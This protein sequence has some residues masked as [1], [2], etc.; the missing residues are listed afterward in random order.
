MSV[1]VRF[2]EATKYRPETIGEHPPLDW[3]QQ[4]LPYKAYHAEPAVELAPLLPFD[5]NPFT[6]QRAT[7]VEGWR[8]RT[9]AALARWLYF[10]YGITAIV[11]QPGRP[12]YLRAAPSAGGLYPVELY[13]AVRSWPDL[14]PG[15]YGFDPVRHRLV[16]LANGARAAEELAAAGYGS[17][18]LAS[19]PLIVAVTGVFQRSRWRYQERAY[20]RILL[21][22]GHVL[23]N[24]GAVAAACGLRVHVTAAFCDALAEQA[25]RLD[26][27]AEGVFALVAVDVAGTAEPRPAW[28]A[29]PSATGDAGE[30]LDALHAASRLPASRPGIHGDDGAALP[31]SETHGWIAGEPLLAEA[32]ARPLPLLLDLFGTVLHRRSC[33]RFRCAPMAR[34]ALARIL[35]TAYLPEQVGLGAQPAL[36]RQRLD[37]FV[38]VAE[39]PGLA[40]GVYWL[41]PSQLALHPVRRLEPREALRFLCLGQELAGD[42]AATVFHT[43][44]LAAA[45]RRHGE[46]AYRY[47]HL[48]A[49][50]LGQRLN[51]AAVAEDLGASGI[52]GFFDDHAA[53]LLGIPREQAIV[54]ITVLGVPDTPAT[55]L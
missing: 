52:G 28:V 24:A 53:S 55:R 7:P 18:A 12:L 4:P 22:A 39:V 13:F 26:P 29:L 41:S 44:D 25:L 43:A 30:T 42:A 47:L 20:R 10:T 37:T 11:Q 45:V 38:V 5:P 3:S 23:G 2:H 15:L 16:L 9:L 8:G 27:Q 49:G 6:G 17:A 50:L 54:Y 34:D 32:T 1:A 21:D 48:D 35:A 33:R 51:L 19:A 46:R 40:P 14:A 36:D 31:L